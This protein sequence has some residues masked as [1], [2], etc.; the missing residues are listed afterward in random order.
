MRAAWSGMFEGY[1]FLAHCTICNF[2]QY[3]VCFGL[4]GKTFAVKSL[5][6]LCSS[7]CEVI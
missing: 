3:V 2:I 7:F 6:D 5:P 4:Q 1:V